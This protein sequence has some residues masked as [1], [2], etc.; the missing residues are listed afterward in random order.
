M[1]ILVVFLA[2][3]YTHGVNDLL[4]ALFV[5]NSL[6]CSGNMPY[7]FNPITI[8]K[9]KERFLKMH[10]CGERARSDHVNNP[11]VYNFMQ[12][13]KWYITVLQPGTGESGVILYRGPDTDYAGV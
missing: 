9:G 4:K 11:G 1:L 6:M 7:T 2:C 12:N 3:R 5:G 13:A 8:G 10:V